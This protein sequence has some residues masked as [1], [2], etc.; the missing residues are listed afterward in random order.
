MDAGVIACVKKRYKRKFVEQAVDLLDSGVFEN[1]YDTDLY[2]AITWIYDIWYRI[3]P[4]L[5]HNCWAKT[6]LVDRY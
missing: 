4:T 6:R 1:L 2:R 3:Q 5:I